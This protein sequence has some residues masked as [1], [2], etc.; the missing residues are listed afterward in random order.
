MILCS[1]LYY[2]GSLA[3]G[4]LI[5]RDNRFYPGK[6]LETLPVWLQYVR[7][8]YP[9]A[10][11]VLFADTASPIPWKEVIGLI[12]ESVDVTSRELIAYG[13]PSTPK[14]HVVPLSEHCGKYFWPMQRNLVEAIKLAYH[15]DADLFWLDADAFLNT[16]I[17]PLVRG[18]DAA[19][20][21]IAHHQMTMDSVCTYVSAQRL[22]ALDA[23]DISLPAFLTQM[24]NEG[25]TETRM[26]ALQEGGLY[27]L[28]AYGKTLSF[29]SQ[30][31]LTHLSCYSRFMAFLERNPLDTP[32]YQ[33]LRYMLASLDMERLKGVDLTFLDMDWPANASRKE[34]Q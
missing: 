29:G 30:V 12:P 23:L 28:F 15:V 3:K 20:P 26:H 16:D 14:V 33:R 19:A 11:L 18:Y 17:R 25:P 31:E 34:A 8:H 22:H 7:R 1:A 27:K 5:V 24:L 9:D 10:H 2:T 13:I 21:Q 4:D 6:Y 32:E